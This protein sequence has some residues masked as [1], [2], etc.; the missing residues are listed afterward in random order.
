MEDI[1]SNALRLRE[2]ERNSI[3]SRVKF[4][5][6]FKD[7]IEK[8]IDMVE[9]ALEKDLRK[10]FEVDSIVYGKN[11]LKI[12]MHDEE[13]GIVRIIN[14]VFRYDKTDI[15]YGNTNIELVSSETSKRPKFHT[16]WKFSILDREKIVEKV[17]KDLIVCMREVD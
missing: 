17:L 11:N 6:K 8:T 16:V 15:R 10:Y 1:I 5:W 3:K 9:A 14:C 12:R 13:Q 2:L 7:E 4:I